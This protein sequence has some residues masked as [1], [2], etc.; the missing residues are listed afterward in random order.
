MEENELLSWKQTIITKIQELVE[1]EIV[2]IKS[3]KKGIIDITNVEK[4][5]LYILDLPGISFSKNNLLTLSSMVKFGIIKENDEVKLKKWRGKVVRAEKGEIYLQN[6]QNAL[7]KFKSAFLLVKNYF[8]ETFTQNKL[9]RLRIGGKPWTSLTEDLQQFLVSKKLSK[10]TR[11]VVAGAVIFLALDMN[12]LLLAKQLDAKQLDAKQLDA[13]QLDELDVVE[14]S[15]KMELQTSVKVEASQIPRLGNLTQLG[16]AASARLMACA[17]PDVCTQEESDYWKEFLKGPP[18]A[19]P[20][21]EKKEKKDED[22]INF[23]DY[24]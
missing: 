22:L 12:S 21:R 18:R 11:I 8:H 13:K 24:N 5:E 19:F 9:Q 2:Q 15:A 17:N 1:K 14:P 3:I 7:E 16:Y 23:E 20:I 10:I 4:D 6:K